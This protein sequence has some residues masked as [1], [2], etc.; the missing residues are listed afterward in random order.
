M[1]PLLLALLIAQSPTPE[2]PTTPPPL[3]PPTTEPIAPTP[4]SASEP[5]EVKL[6]AQF[7]ERHLLAVSANGAGFEIRQRERVFRLQDEDFE[8]A[9]T[10]VPD[11]LTAAKV[12]HADFVTASRLQI[13]GLALSGAAL[14][15]TLVAMLVRSIALPLL[16]VALAGAVVGLV[17]ALIALPFAISAQTKFFGAVA[18]YNRGLLDLRPPPSP[19]SGGVT[20]GTIPPLR[21]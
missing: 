11:A 15:A 14:G 18:A 9:F 6:F 13:I 8:T 19:L 3:A 4:P 17:I 21:F 16:V 7:V 5:A 12:A 10:L 1:T 2:A 20:Y